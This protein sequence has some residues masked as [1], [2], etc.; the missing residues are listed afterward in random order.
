MGSYHV[1]N[2]NTSAFSLTSLIGDQ[3]RKGIE[4][5]AATEKK[6]EKGFE[7]VIVYGINKDLKVR[8][9]ETLQQ[10]K[11]RAL[12][13]FGISPSEQNEFILRTKFHGNDIP[14]D[15]SKTV[16]SYDIHPH[17]KVTLASATPFGSR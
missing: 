17:Q 14:L 16:G 8:E 1:R 4:M 13:L 7:I 10:V 11:L 2:R 3:P 15:E 9:D 6:S 5:E 12:S